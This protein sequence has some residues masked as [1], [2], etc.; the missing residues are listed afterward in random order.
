MENP[1]EEIRG[2][3]LLLTST[4]SLDLQKRAVERFMTPDVAFRHPVCAVES[5][6]SSRKTVL[7]IYQCYRVLSP[8]I[9]AR[10][11][12]VVWDPEHK[13]MFLDIQQWFKLF[14]LPIQPAPARLCTRLTLQ[15]G[16]DGLYYIAM[17]EDFYHPDDFMALLLPP[18]VPFIRMVLLIAGL[19]SS[20]FASF[21]HFFGFWMLDESN[22]NESR[23]DGFRE[24]DLYNDQDRRY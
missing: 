10:V 6:P 11:N 15:R 19:T 20:L 2:V 21:S 1:R 12:N 9:E 5:G 23:P 14:N 8:H 22:N 13:Y 3:I 18:L 4:S 7:G 16:T 17:Q 24:E